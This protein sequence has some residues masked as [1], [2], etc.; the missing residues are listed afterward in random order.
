M[1]RKDLFSNKHSDRIL[2]YRG[3][4]GKNSR[5]VDEVRTSVS[6]L[7]R[8]AEVL[9]RSGRTTYLLVIPDKSTAY[10]QYFDYD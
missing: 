4:L 1:S 6:K 2:F 5:S 3:D 9:R 8:I 7:E 10:R